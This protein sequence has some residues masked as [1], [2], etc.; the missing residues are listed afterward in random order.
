MMESSHPPFIVGVTGGSGSGKTLFLK[1]LI[2]NFRDEEICLVCQDNYYK[3]RE[4]QPLDEMGIPNFD[5]PL[6]LDFDSFAH[7][8]SVLKSGNAIE[9]PEYTY[10]NPV[11]KSR[12]LTLKPAPIIIVEGIFVFYFPQVADQL[13]LKIF[14]DAKEH[15]KLSRRI[16]RDQ[17]ERGYSIEDV[18]Y[19]YEKHVAPT[20]EKYIEPFKHDADLIVPNNGNFDRGLDV[21]VAYLKMK[22]ET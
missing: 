17:E 7:D 11:A 14:I 15:I 16:K 9:R 12:M 1:K 8:I 18:L 10:N 13:D 2:S 20:Y 22:K 5:T 6:S 21:V 4:Q 19:R 3:P